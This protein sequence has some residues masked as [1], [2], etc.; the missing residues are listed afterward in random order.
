[1]HK[2]KTLNTYGYRE[3]NSLIPFRIGNGNIQ[4]SVSSEEGNI[5]SIENDGSLLAKVGLELDNQ[6]LN[7]IDAKQ[8]STLASVELPMADEITDVDFEDDSIKL[9]VKKTNGEEGEFKVGISDIL[10][11]IE[12]EDAIDYDKETKKIS[13][14]LDDSTS[15][16]TISENGLG[17]DDD[18]IAT[19]DELDELSDKVYSLSGDVSDIMDAIEDIREISGETAEILSKID[20]LSAITEDLNDKIEEL[21]GKTTDLYDD[22]D[23]INVNI[24]SI[25][26]EING[27]NESFGDI[28]SDLEDLEN[29]VDD[30]SAKTETNTNDIVEL[31]DKLDNFE[32][33]ISPII[34]GMSATT[35]QNT[36]DIRNLQN[37]I[38]SVSGAVNVVSAATVENKSLINTVDSNL[39][40]LISEL[41]TNIEGE[42]SDI[43]NNIDEINVDISDISDKLD[44]KASIRY[45]DE[46]KNETENWVR[47]NY[48]S[49]TYLN[50]LD[51]VR[52]PQ[53]NAYITEARADDKYMT[54]D[55]SRQFMSIESGLTV[56][57]EIDSINETLDVIRQNNYVTHSE[58]FEDSRKQNDEIHNN[59]D[60]IAALST[61]IVSGD[62]VEGNNSFH[63]DEEQAKLSEMPFDH[64]YTMFHKLIKGLDENQLDGLLKRIIDEIHGDQP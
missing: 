3:P 61:S 8:G 37:S 5:I 4:V 16:L 43:N 34:S 31:Y 25:N 59:G 41:N 32:N 29:K 11:L 12:G 52:R 9:N 39:R 49:N 19:Q 1:M 10:N 47:S 33:T 46:K 57:N 42:I 60:R 56:V 63:F 27:L 22:I 15:A 45:V 36:I 40:G 48:V 44:E 7:L 50:S 14:K 20:D 23:D 62:T 6:N 28:V 58:F 26:D 18:K 55:M 13:L 30:L 54:K 53:L 17:L 51:L 38:N 64:L 24:D 21:S 35:I 2:T